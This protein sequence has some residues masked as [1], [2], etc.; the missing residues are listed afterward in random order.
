[1]NYMGEQ[2][3]AILMDFLSYNSAIAHSKSARK[4]DNKRLELIQTVKN[5]KQKISAMPAY[6]GDKSLR[7]SAVAFL[8]ISYLILTDDYG[9]IINL[10]DVA[11]QSYDAMEAYLLARDMAGKKLD[12][13]SDRL[14]ETE[15]KFAAAHNVNLVDTTSDLEVKAK[16]AGEVND[17]YRV[18]YLIFFKSY[19]Q[20]AYLLD[21][22]NAKNINAIEQNR[23]TLLKYSE[24]GLTKLQTLAPYTNDKS[25][26]LSCQQ[27]L[28]FYQKE[29]KEKI[30]VYTDYF[31]KQENFNK[32]KKAFDAKKE[33]DRKQEVVDQYKQAVKDLNA[34][35]TLYNNNNNQV[36]SSR[37][38]LIDNWNKSVDTFL[39]KHT[40]KYK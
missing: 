40:P 1:M 19:K 15:K 13:A 24:E 37:S 34:A 28:Q 29:C 20:E 17:Y 33:A 14:N 21:A 23:N 4:A 39:Q 35:A 12:E 32:I 5:A 26:I 27:M 16:K 22:I 9:K 2:Y 31:L 18:I 10:E 38:T 8:N 36:N 7:D 3:E 30:Q 11:E 25:L 6:E